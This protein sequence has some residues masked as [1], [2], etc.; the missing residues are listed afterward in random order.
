MPALCR[1]CHTALR[2]CTAGLS[3]AAGGKHP[4][5]ADIPCSCVP[6]APVQRNEGGKQPIR[7]QPGIRIFTPR[8]AHLRTGKTRHAVKAQSS[9]YKARCRDF[10]GSNQFAGT[11]LVV[12]PPRRRLS[13]YISHH[14]SATLLTYQVPSEAADVL[15]RQCSRTCA[16]PGMA[17]KKTSLNLRPADDRSY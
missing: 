16:I 13:S 2:S 15:R 12:S 11:S 1:V 14:E 6:N 10:C 5:A 7:A 17:Q 9:P 3:A 4:M 8:T